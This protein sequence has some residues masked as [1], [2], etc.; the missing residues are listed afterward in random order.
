MAS[1]AEIIPAR[2]ILMTSRATIGECAINEIVVTTNQGFK[3]FVPETSTDVEYLYY[4]LLIQKQRFISLSG[5]ST[6]LEIGKRQLTKYEVRLPV[7]KAEQQAI[8]GV[9]SDMDAEIE[10]LQARRDKARQVKQGLMQ[11]LLS[12]RMR[13][14]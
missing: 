11:V 8:A 13:L 9:L 3:S 1:S 6:F 2:S 4:L 10:A 12:G 7:L 14:L 5:G